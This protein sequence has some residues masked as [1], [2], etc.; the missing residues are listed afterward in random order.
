MLT[1][2]RRLGGNA[3]AVSDGLDAILADAAKSARPGIRIVPIYDQAN[4]V[5]TSIANVRDAIVM[6]GILSVLILLVFLKSLRA[7]LIA[8]LAIPLSLVISFVFLASVA[9]R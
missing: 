1:V 8:S 7:T 2:F 4:L 6:G 5:R 3:L 9:T